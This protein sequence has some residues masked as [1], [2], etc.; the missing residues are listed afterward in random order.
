MNIYEDDKGGRVELIGE[1]EGKVEFAAAGGGFARSLPT[2]A[3]H[4]RYKEAEP[5]TM[6]EG[7]VTAEFL[8]EDVELRCWS[9]GSCWNGWGMPLFERAAVAQLMSVPDLFP[10]RW[11][12]NGSVIV[13]CAQEG[14]EPDLETYTPV[15]MPNGEAAWAIGSGS[16]CWDEVTF[17]KPTSRPRP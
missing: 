3:F 5:P 17:D 7:I 16:W 11:G 10:M 15:T 4:E 9:D 12:A 14:D 13:D 2:D 6:R 1:R 8:G